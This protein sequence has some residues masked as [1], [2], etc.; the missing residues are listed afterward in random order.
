MSKC[1]SAFNP[2]IAF[3]V[4][5]YFFIFLTAN[6]L[7]SYFSL[8]FQTSLAVGLLGLIVPFGIALWTDKPVPS[9]ETPLHQLEFLGET[10]LWIWILW[11]A[12]VLF[13][14]FDKLTTLSTWPIYDEGMVG[15]CSLQIAQKGIHHLF[16]M[17]SQIPVFYLWLL[18]CVF[19]LFGPSLFSLWFLPAIISALWVPL[20]YLTARHYFSKSFSFFCVLLAGL[21][22]W[23]CYIGRFSVNENLLL[24]L[25]T[26][27]F[28]WLAKC[29]H[30][31][32]DQ[33]QNLFSFILGLTLGLSLYA[34]FLHWISVL[35]M[36]G[37]TAS[38]LF[39][40]KRPSLLIFLGAGFAFPAIPFAVIYFQSENISYFH[41]LSSA[42]L[43]EPW[44]DKLKD[45]WNTPKGLFWGVSAH[46]LCYKP[47][48]GGLINPVLGALFGIGLLESLKSHQ[49]ALYRWLSAAGLIFL[50]PGML[51]ED[52]EFYRILPVLVILIPLIALGWARLTKGFSARWAAIILFGLITASTALDFHQLFQVYPHLWDSPVYWVQEF[53]SI[54]DDR[55]YQL[56]QNKAQTEGPGFVFADFTPGFNDQNLNL[57]DYGFN[58]AANDKLDSEKVQWAALVVNVNY[59]PF[60]AQRLGAG[61]TYWL[62]KDLNIPDGGSML[63]IVEINESNRAIFNHWRKAQLALNG[64]LTEYFEHLNFKENNSYSKILNALDQTYPFFQKDPFLETCYWE[65]RADLFSRINLFTEAAENL[66]NAVKKGY[67][68]AHLFYHLGTLQILTQKKA[69][70]EKYLR[71]AALAPINFTQSSSLLKQL[72]GKT[73]ASF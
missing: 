31:E 41:L 17:F 60:L 28:L 19:K 21:S 55:A 42:S 9:A 33:K 30:A 22:F 8:S 36:V 6:T 49:R 10:P 34:V 43:S 29:L 20:A 47:L 54:N 26:L 32:S 44:L 35:F 67:P 3:S 52:F 68:A 56:L 38:Y 66:T 57:A 16:Y 5:I 27:A 73:N 58:A 18:S 61:K 23:P 11:S 53:K 40:K 70:A 72:R 64:Y 1:S 62:S 4:W 48:W 24:P 7:L 39:W 13:F 25:E 15:F 14:R 59:Q 45:A 50:L 63:W 65:K 12:A 69:E 2:P 71:Q 51:V 46:E 37:L